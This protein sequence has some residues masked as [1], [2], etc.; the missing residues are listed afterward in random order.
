MPAAKRSGKAADS[1]PKPKKMKAIELAPVPP[2]LS[3]NA[4]LQTKLTKCDDIILQ[5]WPVGMLTGQATDASG[6]PIYDLRKAKAALDT[7]RKYTASIP[8][9]WLNL[10][11]EMQPG[12]PRY[13]CRIDNLES[14]YFSS[15]AHLKYPLKV[16]V[17][18]GEYP[19]ECIGALNP[20]DPAEMRDALRQAV[21]RAIESKQSAS[22][23][24][25]WK[26][27]LMSTVVE[28]QA[29]D[30]QNQDFDEILG[31]LLQAFPT[32]I[33]INFVRRVG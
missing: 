7:G 20:V 17:L 14:H 23:L 33:L 30:V 18:D 9:F 16:L 11:F 24:S 12:V 13:G 26:E 22:V 4:E 19:H 25:D 8:Y 3:V 1:E 10:K 6:V 15:P 31:D 5:K 29:R 2:E 27:V 21:A 28:F 32:T